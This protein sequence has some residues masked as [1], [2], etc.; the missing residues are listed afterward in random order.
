MVNEFN[1]GGS[2]SAGTGNV[3]TTTGS[4]KRTIQDSTIS[5]W[6]FSSKGSFNDLTLGVKRT[7]VY[8][9]SDGTDSLAQEFRKHGGNYKD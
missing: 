6:K 4:N 7:K 5:S 8:H 3:S 1:D 2:G 9:M